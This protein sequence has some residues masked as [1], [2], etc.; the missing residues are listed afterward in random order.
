[1]D[2]NILDNRD[3]IIITLQ[4][5][6]HG[7]SYRFRFFKQPRC[8]RYKCQ[9]ILELGMYVLIHDIEQFVQHCDTCDSYFFSIHD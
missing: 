6:E 9:G 1:M 3:T 5:N 7:V 2:N 8:P 4:S